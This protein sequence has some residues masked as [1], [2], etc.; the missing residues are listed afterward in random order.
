MAFGSAK[1][2][3]GKEEGAVSAAEERAV[4]VATEEEGKTREIGGD[5]MVENGE[6]GSR[7][8]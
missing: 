5:G 6:R 1:S 2:R 7:V 4:S 3:S 8:D